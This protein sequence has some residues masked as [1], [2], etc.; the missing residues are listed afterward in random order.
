[1]RRLIVL[2]LGYRWLFEVPKILHRDISL[3]NL[4][5]RKE[6]DKVYAVLN[7]FD[8]AV[9]ADVKSTSSKQ[10]TGTKPFMAIDL[11]RP[12]PPVHMCRHDLESM[13]YVLVWITSRFHGGK[14]I[15]DA[16]LQEWADQGGATL[17][18]KKHSFIL[19][20]PPPPTPEFDLLGHWV[21]SLQTMI[22]DGFSA[23][24]KYR[25]ELAVAVRSK[26]MYAPAFEDE[27]LGGFVTFDMFAA[28]LDAK[29]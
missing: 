1:V 11:L 3:N 5:L 15:A 8:L 20:E 27:T 26:A 7:D 9:S 10:R 2:I 24:T 28:I 17:V 21:V 19:S 18:D 6:G 16:P 23:R 12:D 29:L 13:F 22:R 4:M 14:E 25:S